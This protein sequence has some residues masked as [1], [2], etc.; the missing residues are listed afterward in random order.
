MYTVY[1]VGHGALDDDDVEV[2]IPEG[3]SIHFFARDKSSITAT[4]TLGIVANPGDVVPQGRSVTGPGFVDQFMMA[5]D[6]RSIIMWLQDEAHHGY[7]FAWVGHLGGE[8]ALKEVDPLQGIPLCKDAEGCAGKKEH[9]CDGILD[10]LKKYSNICIVSCSSKYAT[11]KATP[12]FQTVRG[13]KPA[14]ERVREKEYREIDTFCDTLRT[15]LSQADAAWDTLDERKRIRFRL[16]AWAAES[17]AQLR[18]VRNLTDKQLVNLYF[19]SSQDGR[20]RLTYL[21][22]P[23]IAELVEARLTE[24]PQAEL[25]EHVVNSGAE[26][27]AAYKRIFG[28]NETLVDN[29]NASLQQGPV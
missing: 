25:R 10:R 24:L 18:S 15:N 8:A 19:Q 6:Y 2:F 22:R 17:Y 9:R 29:L 16:G 14:F 5:P 3:M 21:E 28:G 20:Q 7:A 23:G 4:Q 12:V 26:V 11:G 27:F 13:E 1:V